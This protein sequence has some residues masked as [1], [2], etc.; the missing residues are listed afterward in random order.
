M[1]V[2]AAT[3][4][5][6]SLTMDEY[7]RAFSLDH[8]LMESKCLLTQSLVRDFGFTDLDDFH[9]AYCKAHAVTITDHI[10]HTKIRSIGDV[11]SFYIFK[12]KNNYPSMRV[13]EPIDSTAPNDILAFLKEFN[14]QQ[15]LTVSW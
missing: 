5:A 14:V 15:L 12:S 2:Q 10:L 3:L 9:E 11:C 1:E 7:T 4:E 13:P 6:Y 8:T